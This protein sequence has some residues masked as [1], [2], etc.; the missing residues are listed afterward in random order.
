MAA[1]LRIIGYARESTRDQ[2]VN[3]FNLDDQEKK[4]IQ[5]AEI[6]YG[7]THY[8]LTIIREEGASA[9]SLDRPRMNDIIKMVKQKQIDIIIIHNLDRLTRQVRDLATL[10]ELFDHYSVSLVSITEKIDTVTPMGRFFIFLIVLI[11]QWEWE[12]TSSRSIR[13]M[14]ESARQGN[15]C[16]PRY[17]IGYRRDPDDN[18]KLIIEPEEAVVIKQIFEDIAYRDYNILSLSRKMT[19]DHVLDRAWPKDLVHRIVNNKIYYGTLERFGMEYPNNTI[20]IIDESLF[21]LAQERL[22]TSQ[23]RTVKREYIYKGIVYCKECGGLMTNHSSRSKSGRIH[24]YYKCSGCHAQV[25]ERE[26][27]EQ[28]QEEFNGKLKDELALTEYEEM[29]HRYEDLSEILES[30]PASVLKYNMDVNRLTDIYA[31]RQED[32]AKLNK[33]LQTIK[34]GTCRIEFN[35]LAYRDKRVFLKEHVESITYDKLCKGLEIKY[36]AYT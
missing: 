35:D 21:K 12:T 2:A 10:L 18:H 34:A 13:G 32:K 30:I 28:Y 6:F 11:A 23:I 3:G 1:K 16:L 20:P 4:I 14:M 15:Y 33:C 5:Y 22:S 31:L 24:L 8:D 26:I 36:I 7:E 19:Q 27:N 9:K 17:P 29:K 25:S